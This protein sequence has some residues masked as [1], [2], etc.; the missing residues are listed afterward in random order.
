MLGRVQDVDEYGAD[1]ERIALATSSCARLVDSQKNKSSNLLT[2]R[3]VLYIPGKT[4]RARKKE[5]DDVPSPWNLRW[6]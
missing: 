6:M 4:Y 5:K 3:R 1:G 2:S